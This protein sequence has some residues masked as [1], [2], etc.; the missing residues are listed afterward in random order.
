MVKRLAALLA[1][2][3]LLLPAAG[4]AS[5]AWKENTPAQKLLKE[6]IENVNRFLVDQ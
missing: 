1:A 4:T 3:I 5:V 6:Y 2:L